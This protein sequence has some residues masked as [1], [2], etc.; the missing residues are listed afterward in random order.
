MK[1]GRTIGGIGFYLGQKRTATVIAG[2]P[3]T[4][5]LMTAKNLKKMEKNSPEVATYFHQFIVQLL[6]ERTTH[7]IRTVAALEK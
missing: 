3:S 2:E 4:I 1:S 6:A 5:Y 7:I